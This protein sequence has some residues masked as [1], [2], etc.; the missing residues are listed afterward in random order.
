MRLQHIV[1]DGGRCVEW[2]GVAPPHPREPTRPL[3]FKLNYGGRLCTPTLMCPTYSANDNHEYVQS[4]EQSAEM[5]LKL[6]ISLLYVVEDSSD[7]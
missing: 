5:H 7:C 3:R 4:R 1:Q 6:Y 2:G